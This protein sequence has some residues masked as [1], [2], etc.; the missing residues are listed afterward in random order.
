M[1]LNSGSGANG[2]ATHLDLF[3]RGEDRGGWEARLDV[4]GR[5]WF[6]RAQLVLW[7]PCIG[8]RL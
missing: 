5:E 4:G 6:E 8:W 1:H 2:E 7:Q 3:E